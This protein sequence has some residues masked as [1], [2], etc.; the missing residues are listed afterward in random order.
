MLYR[1]PRQPATDEPG[2]IP[3]ALL[4]FAADATARTLADPRWL[5]CALGEVLSEPKPGVWFG[6]RGAGPGA[7]GADGVRLDRR[8][9]MLYDDW[10][11]FING[12]S[13]RASGRDATLIRRLADRR[14]LGPREMASLS[15]AARELLDD[16]LAAGWLRHDEAGRNEGGGT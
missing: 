7:A 10:H 8:S 11:V 13:Y 1:D 14:A 4:A 6:S 5:G 16:W 15:A 9:R 2:R 3:G 12:E